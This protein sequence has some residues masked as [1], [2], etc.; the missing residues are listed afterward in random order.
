MIGRKNVDGFDGLKTHLQA[1]WFAPWR[2]RLPDYK[3]T[4]Q[5]TRVHKSKKIVDLWFNLFWGAK[6]VKV[7]R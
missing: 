7:L 4:I 1:L 6:C 2:R 3:R 5:T